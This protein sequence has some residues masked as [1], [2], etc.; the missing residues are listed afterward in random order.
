MRMMTYRKK[1][2]IAFI[3]IIMLVLMTLGVL[4]GNLFKNSYMNTF[5]NQ[6][7]KETEFISHYIQIRGGISVFL[8]NNKIEDLQPLN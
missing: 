6:V 5:N 8:K 3:F 2:F 1:L 4:L 7:Q